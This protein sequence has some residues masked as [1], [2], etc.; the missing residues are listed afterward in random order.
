MYI[1]SLGGPLQFATSLLQSGFLGFKHGQRPLTRIQ[2]LPRQPS[3]GS[4][5]QRTSELLSAPA[6]GGLPQLRPRPHLPQR[7][8]RGLQL[9]PGQARLCCHSQC[10]LQ[11][12][13][14]TAP[15]CMLKLSPCCLLRSQCTARDLGSGM[16]VLRSRRCC[17]LQIGW[18]R[19]GLWECATAREVR[20]RVQGL[21]RRHARKCARERCTDAGACSFPVAFQRIGPRLWRRRRRQRLCRKWRRRRP[22]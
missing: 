9:L 17:R 18:F 6:G 19:V 13:W 16:V 12:R 22:T 20:T 11:R 4:S 2:L 15:S 7:A 1:L 14:L 3:F 8:L 10:L 21:P 5:L